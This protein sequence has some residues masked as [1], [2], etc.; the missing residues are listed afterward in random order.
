LL[1]PA[2]SSTG[3]P[4]PKRAAPR[5]KLGTEKT[6]S[7]DNLTLTRD[8]E[9]RKD[10][11]DELELISV[12]SEE[13]PLRST[14]R[15]RSTRASLPNYVVDID[16]DEDEFELSTKGKGKKPAKVKGKA[17]ATAK[18]EVLSSDEE[19]DGTGAYA[20]NSDDE[21]DQIAQAIQASKSTTTSG[22]AS[23][24]ASS[25]TRGKKA[26]LAEGKGKAPPLGRCACC[27]A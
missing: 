27:P 9:D 15:T 12:S 13:A 18:I 21:A 3:S 4:A 2:P 25:S 8:N 19:Y 24:A 7:M 1:T 17:K 14:R 20:L 26:T 10:N 23:S 11:K 16:T 22:R 5:S 6:T